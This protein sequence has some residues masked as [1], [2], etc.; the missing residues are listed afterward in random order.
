MNIKYDDLEKYTYIG[1]GFY[2]MV[3]TDSLIALKVYRD[4]LYEIGENNPA[5]KKRKKFFYLIKKR[6]KR[7]KYTKLPRERLYINNMFS[8][9]VYDFIKGDTLIKVIKYKSLEE[10]KDIAYQ[11]IR[12]EKE[13]TNHKIYN[14]DLKLDNVLLDEEGYVQIIDTDDPKTR[15]TILPNLIYKRICLEALK[16]SVVY[17]IGNNEYKFKGKLSYKNIKKYVKSVKK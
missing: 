13:L 17:I 9:V 10:R 12:N 4:I 6:C 5:L 14:L 16:D 1:K 11:L 3:K 7:I 8:G 15:A 2:G